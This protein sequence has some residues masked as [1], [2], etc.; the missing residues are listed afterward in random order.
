ME[1]KVNRDNFDEAKERAGNAFVFFYMPYLFRMLATMILHNILSFID[2][3]KFSQS[4]LRVSDSPS[5]EA[6]EETGRE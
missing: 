4:V 6:K 1:G 5:P 2:L 3:N